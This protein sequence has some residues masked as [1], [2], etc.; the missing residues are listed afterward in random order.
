MIDESMDLAERRTA[1][2][3]DR[4]VLASERTFA[5]WLRTGY[6][7]VGIALGFHALF[8]ELDPP[9]AAR[10]IATL[11]LLIAV[12][13]FVAAQRHA[14]AVRRRLDAHEIVAANGRWIEAISLAS[15]S[16]SVAWARQ[17]GSCR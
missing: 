17:S 15:I 9:W 7:A 3:E 2:A 1:L 14:K 4:T 13:I 11:F 8:G 16:G 10:F 12:A 5:G 6:A